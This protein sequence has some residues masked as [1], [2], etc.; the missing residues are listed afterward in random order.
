MGW[1]HSGVLHAVAFAAAAK[2]KRLV[3]FHHDP[4]HD[5]ATL[6]RLIDE[7]RR[8][9]EVSFEIIAGTEGAC[10]DR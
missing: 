7:A 5:D 8:S 9:V 4:G 3:T 1:G 2:V 10:F 6:D